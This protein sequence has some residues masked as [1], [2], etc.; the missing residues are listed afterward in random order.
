MLKTRF[1]ALI[2][3]LIALLLS[4]IFI[5]PYPA[6]FGTFISESDF[7]IVYHFRLPAVLTAAFCGM[8]LAVSGHILQQL[9][10]NSLAGPYILGVS[11]GASLMVALVI[12]SAGALPFLSSNLSI[13]LAGFFGALLV[14]LLILSVSARFGYG[15]IILLFGVILGQLTGALQNLLSYLA[16]PADLKYFTLW[17]MG[18]FSNTIEFDLLLLGIS[19]G[20]G[21][22]WAFTLMPSLSVMMLGDD[23]ARTLGVNTRVVAF[24]LLAITGLLT[25]VATAYCGPVAFIGMAIPNAVKILFKTANFKHLLIANALM[26]ACMAVFSQI[27]SSINIA[28]INIPVNVSTALIGGPFIIYILFRKKH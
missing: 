23:V 20:T 7:S 25:G 18:S 27:I 3:V 12:I 10:K 11:S 5:F 19:T 8:A 15:A 17:S 21:L 26:G 4:G 6:G 14:L 28:S 1:I 22:I 9:F 24:Q 13:P 16:N 2:S